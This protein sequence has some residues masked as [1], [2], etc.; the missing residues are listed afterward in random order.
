MRITISVKQQS[1]DDQNIMLY[2]LSEGEKTQHM[3]RVMRTNY[4]ESTYL[5][6]VGPLE[7]EFQGCHI[8]INDV[9]RYLEVQSREIAKTKIE[10]ADLT[11]QI[12]DLQQQLD[13]VHAEDSAIIDSWSSKK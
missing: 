12:K 4:D 10:N 5:E 1:G 9:M 7:I 11:E 2:S 8:D 6:D 13:E 3:S